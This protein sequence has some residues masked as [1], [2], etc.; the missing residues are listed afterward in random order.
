MENEI[1]ISVQELSRLYGDQHAIENVSFNVHRGEILGFL[2]P[3][4]AGKSTTMQIIC[5]VLAANHGSVSIA[6]Y[7]INESP[8]QAK[9]H[10]GF[11]PEQPPLYDD[12]TVDEY[13]IYAG[14]LRGIE[15]DA[16]AEAVELSKE[17]CGLENSGSRLIQNLSKG[18]KQRVGIAQAI[19]HSPAVIILDEPTSGLDPIQIREIRELMLELSE[20]HSVILSTHILSEVQSLCDRVMIINQGQI[21][22]D[23]T[24]E[25]LQNDSDKTDHI[26][27]ALHNPPA[28]EELLNIEGVA[29]AES[30][31]KDILRINFIPDTD[32][33]EA[34]VEKAATEKWG[35]YKLNPRDSSLESIFMQLT[36]GDGTPP[37]EEQTDNE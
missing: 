20:D 14:K 1:L 37:A 17:R 3:N 18:Y 4:G 36:Y 33:T 2:G 16:I 22:L 27:I 6:G 24:M 32:A 29:S 25:Q 26:E 19:I 31:H 10:I 35:L 12:L 30:N 13:L 28:L 34:I 9:E 11:L 7:D 5:G 21:V 15:K 8:Q 23:K